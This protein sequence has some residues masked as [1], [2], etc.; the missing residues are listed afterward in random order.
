MNNFFRRLCRYTFYPFFKDSGFPY[1]PRY[2]PPVIPT[3]TILNSWQQSD[4]PEYQ[5]FINRHSITDPEQWKY[6]YTLSRQWHTPPRITI[7]TPVFNTRQTELI[8]CIL[9]VRLQTLQHWELIL[10]DDNSTRKETISVLRSPVCRD[11]RIRII[12]SQP[13]DPHGISAA[14]NRAIEKANGDYILFLDHDDR[15]APDA[16][17]KVAQQILKNPDAD[18]IYSDRDMISPTNRRYMHFLKPDWSP[19]TLLSGNYLVHIM[20]FRKQ[21]IDQVGRLQS[22]F[23]GA[24]DHDLLLRCAETNPTVIHI[25]EILYHYRQSEQSVALNPDSKEYAYKAGIRCIQQ[26]LERKNISAQVHEKKNLW[27]G[28]YDVILPV[29]TD[30]G[31]TV[32]P[33]DS[34]QPEIYAQ[35]VTEALQ[36]QVTTPYVMI[37]DRACTAINRDAHAIS[38]VWCA[39]TGIA[40]VSGRLCDS[41]DRIHYAGIHFN[42]DGIAIR[43]Y[44]NF[45]VTEPGYMAVTRILRNIS[46]PNPWNV[47]IKYSLWQKM[48]GFSGQYKG[49]YA[50]LDFA[51]RALQDNYRIL[52]QPQAK[53]LCSQNYSFALQPD[54]DRILFKEK[55][56]IWLSKGDPY[57]NMNFRQDS[58]YYELDIPMQNT[59]T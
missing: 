3:Q 20:C 17:Q 31:I 14:S 18:L 49:P 1:I 30:P 33:V 11:P 24:Q 28:N 52:Y 36:N 9:S 15:L 44:L 37:L 42:Q 5:I 48:H 54:Y 41:T 12:Y 47:M 21:L 27:R 10:S 13:D 45:P 39:L 25:P 4:W 38:A 6:K 8:E 7:I 19:E 46:A 32:I 29:E 16:L 57:Y 51:L 43:S 56:N 35:S 2:Y 22:E 53:F 23:D 26:H 40:M 34:S 50:L 59:A 58:T 55:W